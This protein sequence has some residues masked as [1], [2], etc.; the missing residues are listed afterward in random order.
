MGKSVTLLLM[1]VLSTACSPFREAYR[2]DRADNKTRYVSVVTHQNLD[3]STH[4]KVHMCLEP[5]GAVTALH[6][7][8]VGAEA[9]GGNGAVTAGG[10]LSVD[11]SQS[12][13]TIYTVSEIMQLAHAAF[14]RLCEGV[15]NGD[16]EQKEYSTLLIRVMESTRSLIEA[17]ITANL[18]VELARAEAEKAKQKAEID[19]LKETKVAV[20]KE[21]RALDDLKQKDAA[22]NAAL[23]D[24]RRQ[25]EELTTRIDEQTRSLRAV[26]DSIES[27]EALRKKLLMPAEERSPTK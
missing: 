23:A 7:V 15:G 5:T 1:G 11:V 22:A 14:Y 25:I 10:K 17:Q 27:T 24:K 4:P 21:L 6:G 12:L 26:E 20:E 2:L 16:I 9:Q 18:Q 8:K 13:G 3:G 19:R